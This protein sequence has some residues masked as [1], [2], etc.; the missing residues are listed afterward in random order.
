MGLSVNVDT[1]DLTFLVMHSLG[2]MIYML[3]IKLNHM[4]TAENIEY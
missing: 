1:N 2:C 3:I 4:A